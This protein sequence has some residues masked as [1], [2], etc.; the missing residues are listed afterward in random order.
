MLKAD[1]PN[2]GPCRGRGRAGRSVPAH[3]AARRWRRRREG[4]IPEA[5]LGGELG[6]G[7]LDLGELRAAEAPWLVRGGRSGN[8]VVDADELT[9]VHGELPC[10]ALLLEDLEELLHPGDVL[11]VDV[12]PHSDRKVI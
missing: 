6:E 10:E 8:P 12:H 7:K 4:R 9:R 2:G 3:A 5:V 1:R 11:A